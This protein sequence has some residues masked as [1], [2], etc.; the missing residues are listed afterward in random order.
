[1]PEIDTEIAIVALLWLTAI[2]RA[3]TLRSGPV[4]RALWVAIT[5]LAAS[6]TLRIAPVSTAIDNATG[7][8][9]A[10]VLLKHVAGLLAVAALFDL[11]VLA[12]NGSLR[13]TRLPVA[14]FAATTGAMVILFAV[15]DRTGS[16]DFADHAAGDPLATG[17]ILVWS[18]YLGAA[19]A[20]SA[21][22]FHRARAAARH[23]L[24]RTGQLLL[25]LGTTLGAVYAAYRFGFFTYR[26]VAAEPAAGDGFF[27]NLSD[28]FKYLAM[29][30]IATGLAV[31]GLPG[32]IVKNRARRRLRRLQPLWLA[33]ALPGQKIDRPGLSLTDQLARRQV[34]IHDAMLLLRHRITQRQYEAA[35]TDV[36]EHGPP[37]ADR[38]A[39][40]CAAVL[41]LAVEARSGPVTATRTDAFVLPTFA[42]TNSELHW[43]LRV[44][45]V[46]DSPT[47]HQ[48]AVA[49]LDDPAGQV[50]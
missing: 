4:H 14:A 23:R 11:A 32:L 31:A 15:M 6:M 17:Y 5:A 27:V 30:L 43:M 41:R 13:R 47:V 19:T 20:V 34:E 39:T 25:T 45:A 7:V 28:A 46:W 2:V 36:A 1:M 26:L 29:V 50:A 12:G 18:L 35:L 49:R 33:L 21:W 22:L 40:A 37:D 44:A 16:E 3:H 38:T 10:G 24:V 48:L 42:S 9:A 8:S